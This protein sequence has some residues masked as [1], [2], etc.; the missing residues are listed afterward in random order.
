[1]NLFFRR[2]LLFGLTAF[3]I[4]SVITSQI[5]HVENS[6]FI[7]IFVLLF[8]LLLSLAFLLIF[9]K[10]NKSFFCF[11]MLLAITLALL[12]AILQFSYFSFRLSLPQ[13][14]EGENIKIEATIDEIKYKNENF[15]SLNAKTQKINGKETNSL[16]Q[17]EIN[18]KYELKEGMV[19]A[20]TG[21][22]ENT[23]SLTSNER[24]YLIADGCAAS[25]SDIS[26]FYVLGERKSFG[27]FL[28]DTRN[29]IS[30]HIEKNIKGESGSLMSALLLGKSDSLA[31]SVKFGFRRLGISHMLALSG[32]HLTIMMSV[33]GTFLSKLSISKKLK[34][35]VL[36]SLAFAYVAISG[37]SGSILR[38]AFMLFMASLS[39]FSRREND[40]YT[41][42]FIAVAIIIIFQP[43]AVNDIGLWLS[44]LA[45]FGILIY[46][47]LF[48]EKLKEDHKTYGK[49][50]LRYI[51]LSL[52]ISFFAFIFTLPLTA[53]LF[54]EISIM[55][56]VS[57]LI[58]AILIDAELVLSFLAPF[59]CKIKLFSRICEFFGGFI[60]S[61]VT[62]LANISNIYISV[63]YISFYVAL[64]LFFAYIIYLL[65]RK[66]KFK[67]LL[68]R[69][70]CSFVA[71]MLVLGIC[72]ANNLRKEEFIY[73]KNNNK[74]NDEYLIL[75][76][77]GKASVI[78]FS[79][80]NS[81]SFNYIIN[82]LKEENITEI[83]SYIFTH[84]HYRLTTSLESACSKIK[85]NRVLLPIPNNE[86][87][88]N[89]AKKAVEILKNRNTAYEIYENDKEIFVD[90]YKDFSFYLEIPE[91]SSSKNELIL[92][93]KFKQTNFVYASLSETY[94]S[95]IPF[96]EKTDVFIVGN[97]E[98]NYKM[99]IS[100]LLPPKLSH[101]IA[102]NGDAEYLH[103]FFDPIKEETKIHSDNTVKIKFKD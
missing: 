91:V 60:I 74:T 42:L 32:M 30:A 57:N 19:F 37:F 2:P 81:S 98:R 82:V 72:T 73:S 23:Y 78:D 24:K 1:M 27:S 86:T 93:F 40:S 28:S 80:E 100:Y 45:T 58:F 39:F 5:A 101:L 48:S 13:C 17:F 15:V 96:S 53:L 97:H 65:Y 71:L 36:L 3:L 67:A 89:Y 33:V 16:L 88:I 66:F 85:I 68:T 31:P 87:D 64:T 103:D 52:W 76:D 11:T 7:Y 94:A 12:G 18:T 84:Y 41:S 62:F 95:Y 4:S 10:N 46:Y 43:S 34:T 99:P 9:R 51:S 26:D 14:F 75:I 92:A 20:C 35:F 22:V 77:N 61:A 69:F 90:G 49:R 83:S 29:K 38:A 6:A 47:E 70:F 44:F 59:F 56:P 54:G 25:V 8:L 102:S 21:T 63:S 79:S 50:I 55:T